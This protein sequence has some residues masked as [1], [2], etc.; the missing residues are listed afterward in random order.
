MGR[1]VTVYRK[2]DPCQGGRGPKLTLGHLEKLDTDNEIRSAVRY[3]KKDNYLAVAFGVEERR[4]KRIREEVEAEPEAPFYTY[5]GIRIDGVGHN[6]QAHYHASVASSSKAL[7][8]AI[9]AFY[10]R[11]AKNDNTS[12]EQA[13]F[14][15]G[16]RP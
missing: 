5:A 2:L 14:S 10:E 13:A 3:C 8:K 6:T 7:H 1:G 11:R 9:M 12:L 16:M 15:L 4:V